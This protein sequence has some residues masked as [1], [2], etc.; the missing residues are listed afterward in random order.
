MRR[1][2]AYLFIV[3][4]LGLTFGVSADDKVYCVSE[5]F[6]KLSSWQKNCQDSWGYKLEVD[7]STYNKMEL[8]AGKVARS[9]GDKR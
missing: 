6:K 4:G 9:L 1:L 3:L 5:D 8:A 7:Y 2:L